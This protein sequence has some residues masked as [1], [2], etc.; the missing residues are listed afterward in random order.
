M[1]IV[2]SKEFASHQEKYF[3]MA[4]N[5]QVFIQKDDTVFLLIHK[6]M[7]ERAN[8]HDS[9]IYDEVLPPDD[10]FY[11]AISADEFREKLI[12]ILDKVDKKYANK[13]K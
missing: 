11:R 5:E 13:C 7:D 4:K 10:D 1:T 12:E 9:S 6:G 8:Y 3:E 2:S